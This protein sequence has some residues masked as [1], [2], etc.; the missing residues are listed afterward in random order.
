MR[1]RKAKA[2]LEQSLNDE[3]AKKTL[4]ANK[5]KIL[6]DQLHEADTKVHDVEDSVDAMEK[7]CQ[8]MKEIIAAKQQSLKNL[9]A[10]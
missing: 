1:S 6:R 5:R 7:E 4:D 3:Q 2:A 9:V 10:H 8:S